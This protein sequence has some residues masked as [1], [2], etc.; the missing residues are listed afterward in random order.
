[1]LHQDNTQYL[2]AGVDFME[3]V[4]SIINQPAYASFVLDSGVGVSLSQAKTGECS[5]MQIDEN[6]FAS[7]GSL[8]WSGEA[9]I[10]DPTGAP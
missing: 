8:T 2:Q 7:V 4:L 3:R 6:K 5:E 10:I 1:M 9:L